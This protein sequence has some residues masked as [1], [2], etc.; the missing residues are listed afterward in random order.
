M[1]TVVSS[2]E[3]EVAAPLEL[4]PPF[5]FGTADLV[6]GVIDKFDGMKLVK[7]NLSLS[8]VVGDAFD[9]RVTHVDTYLLDARGIRVVIVDMVREP[10]NRISII[11]FGYV[12][13]LPDVD[14][15]EQRDVVLTALGRRLVDG[16]ASQVGEIHARD[17]VLDVV[18]DDAS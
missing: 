18:L 4:G 15:D 7:G 13:D 12:D 2:W 17:G 10:S 5:A 8:E 16:D 11:A 3:P 6:D 14:V 9:V 1:L